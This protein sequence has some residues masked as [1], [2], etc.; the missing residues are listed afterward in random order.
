MAS[1]FDGRR[2]DRR[3]SKDYVLASVSAIGQ[4]RAQIR[5]VA[6]LGNRSG[7]EVVPFLHR[8]SAKHQC[9]RNSHGEQEP[10]ARCMGLWPGSL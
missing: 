3:D 5:V 8:A 7:G 2:L 9:Y 4:L 10:V 1:Y 6:D